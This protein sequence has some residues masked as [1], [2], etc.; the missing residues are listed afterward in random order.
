MGKIIAALTLALLLVGCGGGEL[1]KPNCG[2]RAIYKKYDITMPS[3]PELETMKLTNSSSDGEVSRAYELDIVSLATYA[4]Q[5]ENI[6]DPIT[7]DQKDIAV[8]P[9]TEPT[10]PAETKHWWNW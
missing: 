2:D 6:L 4:K 8:E 5:L 3:R 10:K 1:V 9:T 7:K